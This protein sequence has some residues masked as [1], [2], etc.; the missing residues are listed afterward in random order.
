MVK[1]E[2]NHKTRIKMY[3]ET[4]VGAVLGIILGFIV[5]LL[6]SSP[7]TDESITRLIFMIF[8]Q[9]IVDA[10]VIFLVMMT[11][12]KF[13]MFNQDELEGMVG[14]LIFTVLF[15]MVQ[16]GLLK[17]MRMLYHKLTGKTLPE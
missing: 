11:M 17:R 1:H 12:E 16:T 13:K 3:V 5:D 4:L 15:F 2:N 8:L 9:V 14:Y 10:T 7:N 6:F